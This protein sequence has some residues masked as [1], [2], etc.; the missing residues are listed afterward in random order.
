MDVDRFLAHA[1]AADIAEV[2]SNS[3]PRYRL[4]KASARRQ[5]RLAVSFPSSRNSMSEKH[6]ADQS[7]LSDGDVLG[8]I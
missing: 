2:P 5:V 8:V 7:G 4:A 6:R 1:A 3:P